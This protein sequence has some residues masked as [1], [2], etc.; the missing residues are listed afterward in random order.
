MR[1]DVVHLPGDAV[2]FFRLRPGH[3]ETT[4]LLGEFGALAK[5]GDE[6]AAGSEI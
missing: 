5:R 6:I 2:A 1:H 4:P 3:F